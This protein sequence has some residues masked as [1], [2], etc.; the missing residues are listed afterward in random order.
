MSPFLIVCFYGAMKKVSWI[1]SPWIVFPS[2]GGFS[3]ALSLFFT[4]GH[5]LF[6]HFLFAGILF[7]AAYSYLAFKTRYERIDSLVLSFLL[8]IAV[9]QLWQISF[10]L[11]N[12][13]QSVYQFALGFTTAGWDFMAIPILFYFVLKLD[14][15]IRL[16]WIA[17]Y[18]GSCGIVLTFFEA[19]R[20]H[21]GAFPNNGG[22]FEPYYL[23]SLWFVCI[24]GILVNS[25]KPDI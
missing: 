21:E 8:I 19:W 6:F 25:R 23:V 4:S 7:L 18:F 12:W 3:L 15:K 11:V 14:G 22:L 17:K 24:M 16:N 20:Y 1:A 9:D 13:T 10:D 5:I 2:V